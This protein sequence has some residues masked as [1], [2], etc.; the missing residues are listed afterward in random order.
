MRVLLL[1]SFILSLIFVG[2]GA[3][4]KD[5]FYWGNY[6]TTL[7]DYKK[8]PD[9]KTLEAHKKELVSVME[10]SEKKNKMVPPG[11]NAE[12]GYLLLKEGQ[13][14]EGLTYLAKEI[15]LYPESTV[16]ISRIKDEY[17]KVKK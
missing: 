4:S 9:E 14:S 16:F 17:N 12:Y 13:E 11:V 6:S 10:M 8:N 3:T 1:L 2:C 15:E 5:S 7:Y